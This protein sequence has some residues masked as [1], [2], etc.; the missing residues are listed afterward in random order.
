MKIFFLCFIASA[1]K[2]AEEPFKL[3]GLDDTNPL[4]QQV[5]LARGTHLLALRVC[6]LGSRP[7]RESKLFAIGLAFKQTNIGAGQSRPAPMLVIN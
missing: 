5:S 6:I 1:I 7:N 2:I 3:E 4:R